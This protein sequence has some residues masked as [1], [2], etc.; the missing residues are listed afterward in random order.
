[1]KDNKLLNINN[2]SEVITAYPVKKRESFTK[3]CT[4]L[5]S[6]V[7]RTQRENLTSDVHRP[8]Q[9]G[10]RFA[11]HGARLSFVRRAPR[12]ACPSPLGTAATTLSTT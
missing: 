8:N 7:A 1:M 5:W 6:A 10:S 2:V 11:I 9:P 4:V 12:V 3:E